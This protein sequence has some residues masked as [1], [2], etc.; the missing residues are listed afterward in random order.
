MTTP[1]TTS[2]LSPFDAI[3][4]TDERGEYWSARELMPLLGY[5][6]TG[7]WQN[8][9][10]VIHEARVACASQGYDV[11]TVFSYVTKNLT[12]AGG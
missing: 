2:P 3:R 8:F 10:R 6:G 4:H 1:T 12:K 9:E 7:N 5:T 11:A